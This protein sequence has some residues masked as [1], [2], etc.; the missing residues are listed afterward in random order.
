LSRCKVGE[1]DH[2]T[3]DNVKL[4]CGKKKCPCRDWVNCPEYVDQQAQRARLAL[5]EAIP[6]VVAYYK[7]D[8]RVDFYMPDGLAGAG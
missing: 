8:V 6:E 2:K 3:G 5:K 4:G 7:N 1:F